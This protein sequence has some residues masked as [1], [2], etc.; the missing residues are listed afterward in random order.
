MNST[1]AWFIAVCILLCVGAAKAGR[2]EFETAFNIRVHAH[3]PRLPESPMFVF[4]DERVLV[5]VELGLYRRPDTP[6]S[7]ESALA[8]PDRW[9]EQ[10]HWE[11]KDEFGESV[12]VSI[13]LVR[14]DEYSTPLRPSQS[15]EAVFDLGRLAIGTYDVKVSLRDI[16]VTAGRQVARFT[17]RT[18]AEDSATRATYLRSVFSRTTSYRERKPILLELADLEPQNPSHYETLAELSIVEAPVIETQEYFNRALAIVHAN[19]AKAQRPK[20]NGKP[21]IFDRVV[22]RLTLARDLVPELNKD[23]SI[24]LGVTWMDGEKR[25]DIRTRKTG[26][27]NRVLQ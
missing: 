7:R 25:Y 11:I 15:I 22:R 3:A 26:T 16:A 1:R 18:G 10:L 21:D 9:W 6:R 2:V 14:A 5:T 8:V 20:K 23:G 13:T 19:A 12:P 17:V 24:E 4:A 27:V